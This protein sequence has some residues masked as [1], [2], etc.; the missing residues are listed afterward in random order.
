[1]SLNNDKVSATSH[2]L[3]QA[4]AHVWN[5]IFQFINSMSLKCAVQLGIPDV[6]HNHGQ[7]ISLS[8]LISGLNVHPSKA[9]FIARLMRILVHSN[10]FAQDQQD[11]DDEAEE[12]AVVVYSL[13]PA[14]RLLLK[15]APLSTT[16]FLLM[17]LDPVV[18][19]PFH[20]MGTWC[21]MNNHGNHD[22]P[23]SPF[24]MA[25]GRPFWGLA[26]QQPKFGSLFNEAMEADSQLIARAVV[27]ECEGV[28]E[29]LNSLVDVGGGTGNMAKAIA[30]AF[31]NINCT[32]LDQPHVVAN[33]Q[34]THNLDFVGGD[35]FE[36][37]P[38]ANAIFLKWILHDWSDEESVKIL[39]KSR[40]AILS[41]NEGGKVIIL[42]I[43]VSADNKKMDKKSIETQL[44]WDMLMMVNLN[45]KERSE[46]EWEKLFLTAGFSLYKITHTLGLRSLIEVYP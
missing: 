11:L 45:G 21:Q 13:T 25:H 40:E 38:P 20:L 32:V 34:G 19:D 10:F 14:S 46:A 43:N 29:G 27:E 39:K 24:E 1:M 8:N 16:Q 31:P 18:T 3:L 12:K 17:I 30:K 37:I 36:K 42:E 9:Y 22:H 15:E 35:M 5:H 7:P 33:L 2:E 26:A 44:M 28:F 4:Q 23:A 41:K 6:I